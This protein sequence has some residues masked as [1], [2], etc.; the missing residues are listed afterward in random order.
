MIKYFNNLKMFYKILLIPLIIIILLLII[1]IFFLRNSLSIKN[2]SNLMYQKFSN[3]KENLSIQFELMDIFQNI[4]MINMYYNS[5]HNSE[6]KTIELIENSKNEINLFEKKIIDFNNK[7]NTNTFDK[8]EE[9]YKI[10]KE[11]AYNILDTILVEVSVVAGYMP[12]LYEIYNDINVIIDANGKDLEDNFISSNKKLLNSLSSFFNLFLTIFV[13]TIIITIISSILISGLITS[14][15]KNILKFL[16]EIS[17]GNFELNLEDNSKDEIGFM[18]NFVNDVKK[19]LNEMII[20]IKNTIENNN[21]LV[22][23][24][25]INFEELSTTIHEISSTM[26]SMNDKV[27][28]LNN[29]I[30][31]T[32]TSTN[33]IND[34]IKNVV[35]LIN[36]QSASSNESS[37]AIEEI[38]ANIN[39]IEKSTESKI[40]LTK[41]ISSMAQ[42]GKKSMNEI[43]DE[44][45]DISKSTDLISEMIKIINGIAKQINLLSMN[46][47][48]EAAHSGEY[49]KGFTVVADEIRKLAETTNKNSKEISEALKSIVQKINKT[50]ISTK[51]TNNVIFEI[52]NGIKEVT[53]EMYETLN[54]LKEIVIGSKEITDSLQNLNK[55]TEELKNAGNNM[56]NKTELIENST[57]NI[58]NIANENTMGINEISSGMSQISKATITL[59][60]LCVKNAKS[61]EILEIKINKFKTS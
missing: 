28:F 2:N 46:A 4:Y 15:L 24:V 43:T 12:A 7:I 59:S 51:I 18:T 19:T 14:R 60:E 39:N 54:G 37:S 21:D 33:N 58:L 31:N 13:F 25:K 61:N 48:I 20:N 32:H 23:N 26:M 29:E 10:F 44:I 22:K 1:F 6:A 41:K 42:D 27:K 45:E 47:A 9:N 52:S 36:E 38:L 49:G 30:E 40:E 5:G 55:L 8:L 16:K 3:Y 53:N 56:R 34:Y 17:T 50:S 57:Q 11:V 35:V